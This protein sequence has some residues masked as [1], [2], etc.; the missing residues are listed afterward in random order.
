MAKLE[1]VERAK[2]GEFDRKSDGIVKRI[3]F[4]EVDSGKIK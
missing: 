4:R 2:R 1:A 3:L